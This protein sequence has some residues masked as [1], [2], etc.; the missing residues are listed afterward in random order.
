MVDSLTC[1]GILLGATKRSR[2][3]YVA[4]GQ[5]ATLARFGPAMFADSRSHGLARAIR[6]WLMTRLNMSKSPMIATGRSPYRPAGTLKRKLFAIL[7][8]GHDH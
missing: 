7:D 8:A 1:I 3:R 6:D 4:V 5:D 2:H